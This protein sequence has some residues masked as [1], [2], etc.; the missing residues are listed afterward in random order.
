MDRWVDELR[1]YAKWN[2]LDK[3][4]QILISL[5]LYDESKVV[6][7]TEAEWDGSCQ[8]TEER[9]MRQY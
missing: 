3:E 5:L 1:R 7:L 4:G 2:K 6:K 8:G 9:E